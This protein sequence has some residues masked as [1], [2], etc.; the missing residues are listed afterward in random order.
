MFPG[1]RSP[2]YTKGPNEAADTLSRLRSEHKKVPKD[3]FLEHLH[4]PS[5]RGADLQDAGAAESVDVASYAIYLVKP[6]WTVMYLDFLV[7]QKLSDDEVLRRQIVRR[8][9]AFTIINGE[10]YKRSTSGVFQRCITQRRA[11]TCWMRYMP[12]FVVITLPP[13]Q[14]YQKLSGK[15]STG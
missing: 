6:N 5:I 8:G 9:K 1:L 2:P 10:L 15:V 13:G 4:K 12:E 3:V 14:L 7:D 11:E